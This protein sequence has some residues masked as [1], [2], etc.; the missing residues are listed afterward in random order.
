MAQSITA[1]ATTPREMSAKIETYLATNFSYVPDPASLGRPVSVD[2]FLLRERRGHCEYFAAGMVVLLHA[3]N[4]PSRIVGGF[5]GGK[6]NPLTGYFVL[7][8]SD[9]HAWVEVYDG[10]K[11]LTFDPTPPALRPGNSNQGIVRAYA[12]ALS[13]SVNYLWDR[14]VLTY[15]FAD[16]VALIAAALERV[17]GGVAGA[18]RTGR[19]LTDPQFWL[20][21]AVLVAGVIAGG[22]AVQAIRRKR[23][24]L[25][26]RMLSRLRRRGIAVSSGMT[27]SEIIAAVERDHPHLL[28]PVRAIVDDYLLERFSA[29]EPTEEMRLRAQEGFRLLSS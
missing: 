3:L 11:W 13:E 12:S 4:V 2:E 1:G 6:I 5:Y 24:P 10:E 19:I 14:Y 23:R 9:A 18:R 17:M 21:I 29:H 28:P 20:R 22:M 15:G 27:A 8:R 7:Q 26:L 16:Q 25:Y